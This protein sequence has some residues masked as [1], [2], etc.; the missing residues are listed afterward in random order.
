M[1]TGVAA[2]AV[3]GALL[4]ALAALPALWP[5]AWVA[6]AVAGASDGRLLLADARGTLWAGSA[7]PVLTGGPGS[8]DASALPD[9]LHWRLALDGAALRVTLSQ[10]CCLAEGLALRVVPGLGRWRVELLPP[11]G[12]AARPLAQWPAAWLAGL[13]TPWNT[14]QPQGLLLLAS[15]GLVLESAQGRWRLQGSA[16]LTLAQFA[17]RVSTLSP[18]G[19]YRLQIAGNAA[20][21]ST[22]QLATLDG[23]LQLQGSGE[24]AASG[25]RF[26]GQASA[27]PGA[28]AVLDNLL[29]I[30]GR[31]QGATAL[32]SIG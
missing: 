16:E 18:L 1:R 22:L 14:L 6:R 13:G 28:E 24:W 3:A 2:W 25:L 11:A 5:A 23:A 29:N 8:R 26:R 15:P 27:A 30:I 32:L 21:V 31:R 4:G 12:G 10:R 19:S 9:R 17:S 7:L 20:G